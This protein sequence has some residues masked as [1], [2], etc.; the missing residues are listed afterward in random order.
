MKKI[1]K[2]EITG[3][4]GKGSMGR[5]FKVEYPVTHKVA[6][7][8]ILDPESLLYKMMGKE[9]VEEIFTKE[10]KTLAKIRHDNVVEI[11]DFDSVDGKLY[12]MMDFYCNNLGELIGESHRRKRSRVVTIEQAIHYTRQTLKGLSCLH[13]SD[14]I[15]RDIKPS[16]L[17]L[18]DVDNVKISDFGLS[19]LRGEISRG[20]SGIR[21]GN[22]YYAAPEQEMDPDNVSFTADIYSV[23]VMVF[24]LLTGMLPSETK[25]RPSAINLDLDENWDEFIFQAMDFDPENR[26]PSAGI[27]LRYLEELE[28]MWEARKEKIC[29]LPL[30]LEKHIHPANKR[31]TIR[32]KPQQTYKKHAEET[33]N[34]D[35]LFRPV[36]Y[37][38]N[39]FEKYANDTLHDRAT[40]LQWQLFGTRFP[41][42]WEEAKEYINRLNQEQWCG[43]SDWRLPT[44]DELLTIVSPL[45]TGRDY[46]VKP[47]F[48]SQQRW[49][50]SSDRCTHCSGWYVSLEM[51]FAAVNHFTSYYHVKAVRTV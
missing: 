3:L 22:P 28:L 11:L 14:V 35:E 44:V 23:G 2:Y 31:K 38:E 13:F 20:H 32:S 5:I 16:N 34:L 24:R 40:G 27:M 8:K 25:R 15:H 12:Y 45:P 10:A 46:C 19:K 30:E 43:Y 29:A 49:V 33:F 36:V 37:V 4:L 9:A 42:N 26:F 47:V 41:M 17:L 39:D 18:T 48:N 1:G 7:L 6:A 21:L 50:W 51:G